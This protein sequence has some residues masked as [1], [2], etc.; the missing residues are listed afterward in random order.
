VVCS[1]PCGCHL[2]PLLSLFLGIWGFFEA[3]VNGT[4]FLYSFSACSL[5]MYRKA[6]YFCKLI[7][8]PATLLKLFMVSRSFEVEFFRFLRYKIMP[9]VNRDSLATYLPIYIPSILI[10]FTFHYTFPL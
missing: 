1:S 4:I 10:P 6:A 2:Q 9:S 8:Y 3:V 7:L 5:L